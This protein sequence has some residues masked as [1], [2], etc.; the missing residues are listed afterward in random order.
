MD[1]DYKGIPLWMT[2]NAPI[3]GISFEEDTFA[4]EG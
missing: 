1:W 4:M 3:N 2:L